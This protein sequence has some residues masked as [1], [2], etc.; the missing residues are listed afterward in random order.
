M[1]ECVPTQLIQQL[2]HRR[3][4]VPRPATLVRQDKGEIA[5][6]CARLCSPRG[7]VL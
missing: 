1:A 6:G 5:A 7:K 4:Q 3:L 2:P